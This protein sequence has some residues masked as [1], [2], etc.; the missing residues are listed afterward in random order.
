MPDLGVWA[1]AHIALLTVAI[2]RLVLRR[3]MGV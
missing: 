3:V 1:S 2:V